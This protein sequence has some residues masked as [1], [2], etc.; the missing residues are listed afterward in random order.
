MNKGK[1][2]GCLIWALRMAGGLLLILLIAAVF[3]AAYEA[4]ASAATRA[5][6]PP[7]GELVDVGG[8]TM[9]IDCR[10]EGSP[11]VILDAGMGGWSTTWV[12]VQPA[13]VE[14]LGAGTTRVCAYD[15]AGYGWSEPAAAERTPQ[16]IAD[17]LAAL[18]DAAEAEGIVEGPYVPVG[19]S[20]S[21]HSTRLFAAQHLD[22]VVGLVLV[23]PS[24]EFLYEDA[25]EELLQRQQGAVGTFQAFGAAAR[26]GLVRLLDPQNMAPTAPMIT[27]N[28]LEPSVYYGFLAEPQWW[29]TFTREFTT[30]LGEDTARHIRENATIS[31]IPLVIIGSDPSLTEGASESYGET[32]SARLQELAARSDQGEFVLAE[33]SSHEIPRDRPEIVV[34]AIERV[35]E[36]AR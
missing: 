13:L 17:D 28:A 16:Q 29:Q 4:R 12:A 7:T 25:D 35:L 22:E 10:G 36:M 15:R 27:E 14:S 5:Q 32:H 24:T 2:R 3:G 18:L 9:H 34:D 6:Y 23:D 30:S 20:Y 21:G 26:V 11:T 31:D 1:R 8:R 19:F 33:G